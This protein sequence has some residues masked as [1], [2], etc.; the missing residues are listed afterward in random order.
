MTRHYVANNTRDGGVGATAGPKLNRNDA[1]GD[2]GV[3]SS[4]ED[5]YEANCRKSRR[6]QAECLRENRAGRGTD[7]EDRCDD[8]VPPNSSVMLIN[9]IFRKKACQTACCPCSVACVVCS[10]SP[11]YC[12]EK[13]SVNNTNVAPPMMPLTGVHPIVRRSGAFLKKLNSSMSRK[14]TIPK[15]MPATISCTKKNSLNTV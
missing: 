3:S 4:G 5:R 12:V 15:K 13:A 1:G 7:K 6:V 8:A 14:A 2:W 10:P 9:T 11:R